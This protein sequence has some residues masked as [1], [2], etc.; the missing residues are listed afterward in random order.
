MSVEHFST[1]KQSGINHVDPIRDDTRLRAENKRLREELA[2][3]EERL[4]AFKRL[5]LPKWEAP[6]ELGLSPTEEIILRVMFKR[7]HASAEMLASVLYEGRQIG[8]QAWIARYV[9]LMR[10]KLAPFSIVIQTNKGVGYFLSVETKSR[11][12]HMLNTASKREAS[13]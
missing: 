8:S 2:E 7:A 6:A 5:V 13:A 12:A 9:Y 4:E 1:I 11:L 10:R 3:M